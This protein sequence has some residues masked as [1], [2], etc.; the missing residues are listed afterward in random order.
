MADRKA[1]KKTPSVQMYL[2]IAEIRDNAIILKEGSLRAVLLVSSINFALK[3]ED[4]QNAIISGYISF[5]NSLDTPLQILVQSRVLDLDT[6]LDSIKS[7][8]EK[9]TNELL[10]LQTAEYRRYISD[11]V[12]LGDI[13]TKRFYVVVPYNILSNKKRSFTKR[14]GDIISPTSVINLSQKQFAKEHKELFMIVDKVLSGL[15]S[16]GLRASILDTQALIELFYNTYNPTVSRREK[17][18][19]LSKL[20]LE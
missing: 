12:S 2:N 17:L 4:E 5:L 15:S 11:L 1:T 6:Y 10:K 7:A 14:I 9:Q 3:A 20:N 18:S 8:E 16:M 19:D 13:M